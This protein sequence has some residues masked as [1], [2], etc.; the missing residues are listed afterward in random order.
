MGHRRGYSTCDGPSTGLVAGR[1]ALRWAIDG[2]RLAGV[3]LHVQSG[4]CA[5]PSWGSISRA[6]SHFVSAWVRPSRGD[7]WVPGCALART[8]VVPSWGQRAAWARLGAFVGEGGAE[9]GG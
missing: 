9:A 1:E 5:V 4:C 3:N 2:V 8:A 6:S 7:D